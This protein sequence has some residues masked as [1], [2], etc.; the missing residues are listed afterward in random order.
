MSDDRIMSMQSAIRRPFQSPILT[1]KARRLRPGRAL[2]SILVLVALVGV[3][4]GIAYAIFSAT[5]KPPAVVPGPAP[6]PGASSA[7][8]PASGVSTAASEATA[9]NPVN[10]KLDAALN[11]AVRL[12]TDREWGKA[13]AVLQ[14]ALQTWPAEQQLHIQLAETQVAMEQYA[15]AYASYERALAIGPREAGV[16]FAAGT[17]ASAANKLDRAAEHFAAAQTAKPTDHLPPLFLAQVQVKQ[18]NL[19][20]AK[21]NLLLSS[22]LKPDEAITWG[23]LAEIAL[24]ENVVNLAV[25][26]AQRARD[27]E[28][29]N[30]LWR[31]VEARALKRDN[32]PSQA[33]ALFE[34]MEP[35]DLLDEPIV[36]LLGECYGLAGRPKDGA[37]M[38]ERLVAAETTRGDLVLQT[39]QWWER[40]GDKAKAQS[41]AQRAM[42]MQVDG[43]EAMFNRLKAEAA[44]PEPSKQEPAKQEPAKQEPAKQ[45]STPPGGG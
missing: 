5:K 11:A 3:G 42:F 1:P 40:A 31:L 43:A 9:S 15:D 23:T 44:K 7:S 45:E 20:E 22:R 10:E 14:E 25:Q 8:N 21:K 27:L 26:H 6:S 4:G 34:G 38:F 12:K 17:A 33:L 19:A 24:R 29:A 16:E 2:A 28:P 13:K 36:Q 39:A 30:P 37:L 41:W 32:K 35:A 18:G